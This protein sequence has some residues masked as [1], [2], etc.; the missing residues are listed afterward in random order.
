MSSMHS[1]ACLTFVRAMRLMSSNLL[2]SRKPNYRQEYL[3]ILGHM[4]SHCKTVYALEAVVGV[5]RIWLLGTQR[6]STVVPKPTPTVCGR[7][8]AVQQQQQQQEQQQQQQEQQQQQLHIVSEFLTDGEKELFLKKLHQY[9]MRFRETPTAIPLMSSYLDI[10]YVLCQSN[11]EQ[12]TTASSSSSS[13]HPMKSRRTIS[14]YVSPRHSS[15]RGR[16]VSFAVEQQQQHQHDGKSGKR[17]RS[18]SVSSRRAVG[19]VNLLQQPFTSAL[20]SPNPGQREQFFALF[21]TNLSQRGKLSNTLHRMRTIMEHDWEPVAARFW[22][23]LAC[24]CLLSGVPQSRGVSL[25]GG[26]EPFESFESC[27][28]NTM[29]R[30]QQ[31]QQQQ[32]QQRQQRQ[33]DYSGYERSYDRYE[34]QVGGSATMDTSRLMERQRHFLERTASQSNF[35]HVVG[36]LQELSHA[37]ASV[38]IEMWNQVFPAMWDSLNEPEQTQLVNPLGRLLSQSYLRYQLQLPA[39]QGY[40]RNI[41]QTLLKAISKCQTSPLIPPELIKYIGKTFNAWHTSI[42]ILE[43]RLFSMDPSTHPENIA[44]LTNSLQWLYNGLNDE[45]SQNGL[46]RM[47]ASTSDTLIT[48]DLLA[49]Q[50]WKQAQERIVQALALHSTTPATPAHALESYQWENDWVTCA[51]EL[52]QW[53]VLKE[54]GQSKDDPNTLLDAAWKLPDWSA[55]KT[56]FNMPSVV[57]LAECQLPDTKLM[58]YQIYAAINE[59]RTV[60]CETLCRQAS[61]LVLQKWQVSILFGPV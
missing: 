39:G 13:S 49:M 29:E 48:L 55:I 20:M 50:Q 5:L 25:G 56:V 44:S 33:H 52:G 35:Q 21:V 9:I 7:G 17:S 53:S 28:H 30:Q 2:V 59:G 58:L 15:S 16:S 8:A 42:A 34:Q 11:S 45:E 51:R 41:V 26:I 24:G 27:S 23:S 4:I 40:K 54:Y 14:R 10:V 46:R 19:L 37:D 36:S 61:Q 60:E 31:Q 6:P 18:P 57:A 22:I 32:Q 1:E 47:T 38:A 12:R 43:R 3:R